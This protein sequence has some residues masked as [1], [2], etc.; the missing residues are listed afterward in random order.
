MWSL[1]GKMVFVFETALMVY[2]AQH[3]FNERRNGGWRV[4]LY[5]VLLLVSHK[6]VTVIFHGSMVLTAVFSGLADYILFGILWP[7]QWYRRLFIICFYYALMITIDLLLIFAVPPASVSLNAM[8]Y[9]AVC[10][11]I[12]RLLLA[13]LVILVSRIGDLGDTAGTLCA[14]V[15]PLPVLITV[16][17]LTAYCGYEAAEVTANRNLNLTIIAAFI[18][19][20]IL[21]FV[22]TKLAKNEEILQE[23]LKMEEELRTGQEKY[24]AALLKSYASVRSTRH[25]MHHYL[26][27]VTA[28]IRTRQY[29]EALNICS[30]AMQ[31]S[32]KSLIFTGNEIV[33]AIIY[34]KQALYE[35]LGVKLSV[36]G[37]LPETLDY[38]G[39][40]ICVVLS[41]AMENAAEAVAALPADQR[42]V[43]VRFRCEGWLLISVENAIGIMPEKSGRRYISGKGPDHGLGLD[44]IEAAC[45]R[46]NGYLETTVKDGVFILAATMQPGM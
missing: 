36:E 45:K 40:D 16:T 13:V 29:G 46:Q 10:M 33:D 43:Y 32:G 41:N 42:M 7:R 6:T 18:T 21:L 34:S 20:L 1:F 8:Q 26:D 17:L 35:Q 19:V 37:C 9:Q 30:H 39:A 2:L 24:C 12:S 15:A 31:R 44:N 5:I 3:F 27:A 38:N 14:F 25:D 11:V 22:Y 23:R 28:F 4:L